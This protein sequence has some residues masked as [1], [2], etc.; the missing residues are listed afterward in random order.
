M[1]RNS[2][3]T[4]W[5][6]V[7]VL[8]VCV[9]VVVAT[10]YLADVVKGVPTSNWVEDVRIWVDPDTNCQYLMNSDWGALTPRWEHDHIG[11]KTTIRGCK[12]A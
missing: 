12:R 1:E 5:F 10:L 3:T 7:A 4:W 9:L 2:D 8:I 6:Y 11:D